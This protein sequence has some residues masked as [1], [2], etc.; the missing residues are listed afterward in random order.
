MK[1]IF[2]IIFILSLLTNIFFLTKFNKKEPQI[3]VEVDTI[4]HRDTSIIS[5]PQPIKV[6]KYE[7]IIVLKKDGTDTNIVD[8]M[9]YEVKTYANSQYK[10]VV[11][12]YKPQLD[13]LYIYRQDTLIERLKTI[14]EKDTRRWGIGVFGGFDVINRKPSLGVGISYN[15]FRF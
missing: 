2:Y 8:T 13:S 15:L 11:S 6:E 7:P 10:A 9:A 12:G 3:T 4:V 14:K 1:K 5:K